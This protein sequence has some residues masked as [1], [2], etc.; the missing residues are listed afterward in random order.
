MSNT[1]LQGDIDPRRL[2]S[3]AAFTCQKLAQ[4]YF[5]PFLLKITKEGNRGTVHLK[6]SE[7]MNPDQSQCRA[8]S[9]DPSDQWDGRRVLWAMRGD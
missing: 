1:L 6:T 4:I 2:L 7:K 9:H 8:V 5:H 3:K